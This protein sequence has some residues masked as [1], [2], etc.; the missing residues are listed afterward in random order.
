MDRK[1]RISGNRHGDLP[2]FFSLHFK[3]DPEDIIRE[4][5]LPP[6]PCTERMVDFLF[7]FPENEGE[8]IEGRRQSRRG[9]FFPLSLFLPPSADVGRRAGKKET[10]AE[11]HRRLFLSFRR[12]E[13]ESGHPLSR[14]E[15]ER[16]ERRTGSFP[17]LP[18]ERGEEW[19]RL[20]ILSPG[21]EGQDSDSESEGKKLQTSS[22]PPLLLLC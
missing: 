20:F 13:E 12:R 17:P 11:H 10:S 4:A 7:F 6:F 8:R 3:R 18:R 2:L 22:P 9:A 1:K 14:Q 5:S 16:K 21:V 15:R 19:R